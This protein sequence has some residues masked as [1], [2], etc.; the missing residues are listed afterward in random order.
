MS[1][2]KSIGYPKI[3][4]WI[5]DNPARVEKNFNDYFA[6]KVGDKSS[7]VWHGQHFEW[8]ANRVERDRFTEV[9]LAAIGALSV[10]LRA[11]TARELIEDKD[12][13]LGPLL[14]ECEQWTLDNGKD[15]S[16]LDLSDEWIE[17]GSSF[18]RLWT[19]ITKRERVGIGQVKASKLMATK[20]P[21]L[22]PI[23]D[24][25]VSWLLDLSR[26]DPWWR[27][28]RELVVEVKDQ[29]GSLT[30]ERDDIQVTALRKLDVVLWMEADRRLRKHK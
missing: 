24:K 15:L 30:L 8:F 3:A 4:Q 26:K 20:Y 16:D 11:Q 7:E 2:N 22:V 27:S 28:M 18:R 29:L 21:G 17:E 12:K 19:E 13:K 10:D 9:D 23:F 14:E 25:D 6:L 1:E 5:R